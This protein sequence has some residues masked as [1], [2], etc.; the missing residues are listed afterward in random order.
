LLLQV[1]QV[2]TIQSCLIHIHHAQSL[3]QEMDTHTHTHTAETEGE[4]AKFLLTLLVDQF[5]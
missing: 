2:I 4:P 1:Q 5:I 3:A